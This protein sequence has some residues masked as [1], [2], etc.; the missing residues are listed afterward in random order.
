MGGK[1]RGKERGGREKERSRRERENKQANF[2]ILLAI[3]SEAQLTFVKT[4]CTTVPSISLYS[5]KKF[6]FLF[7]V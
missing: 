1:E 3:D 7:I 4:F 2:K 6:P 5:L